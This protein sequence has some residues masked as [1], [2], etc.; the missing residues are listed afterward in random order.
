MMRGL[1]LSIVVLGLVACGSSG[2]SNVDGPPG[3]G[4]DSPPGSIDA[5]PNH[6]D[7][8]IPPGCVDG[9]TQCSDCIDNDGDGRIDGFDPECTGA[10]DDDEGSFGTGIPG[11]NIDQ[12]LQDCFFDGNSGGGNDCAWHT[13]CM[14]VPP[15]WTDPCPL[16]GGP[17]WDPASCADSQTAQCLSDCGPLIPPGCDCFGCCTV[18]DDAGC[19]D[20]VMNPSIDPDC[21]YSSI[22]DPAK[23]FPCFQNQ[24]C[25]NPCNA[26]PT[27]CILCPGEDPSDLP[28]GCGGDVMCPAGQQECTDTACPAAQYCSNGCCV[29]AIP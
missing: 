19:E 7:G 15:P 14:L 22:H 21:D 11:D 8:V 6:P 26:D 28:A 17:A 24:E 20:I 29:E 12:Y 4:P 13:C 16:T 23:C 27:D 10:I 2:G 5:D 25:D 18:C 9:G 1:A 3:G